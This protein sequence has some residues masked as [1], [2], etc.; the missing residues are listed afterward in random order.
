MPRWIRG[1]GK[2]LFR[3]KVDNFPFLL[4]PLPLAL[5]TWSDKEQCKGSEGCAAEQSSACK[6][7]G[8]NALLHV[9]LDCDGVEGEQHKGSFSACATPLLDSEWNKCHPS[10]LDPAYLKQTLRIN[11]CKIIT[12]VISKNS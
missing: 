11:F 10:F 5:Q 1:G 4:E 12:K 6:C 2:T 3:K 8:Y 7:D 9:T